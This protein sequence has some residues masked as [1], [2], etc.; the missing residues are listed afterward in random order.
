MQQA[1]TA[2]EN[3]LLSISSCQTGSSSDI[4]LID[5]LLLNWNAIQRVHFNPAVSDRK[6]VTVNIASVSWDHLNGPY[7]DISGQMVILD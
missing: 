7:T 6:S 2:F 1:G 5:C 4:V 3:K